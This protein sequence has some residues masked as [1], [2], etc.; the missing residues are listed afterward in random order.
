MKRYLRSLIER[1]L[2]RLPVSRAVYIQRDQLQQDI[3]GLRAS[4]AVRAV[5][6]T[7]F[8][9]LAEELST[10]SQVMPHEPN[11]LEALVPII[12]TLGQRILMATRCRDADVLPKVANAGA[13]IEQPNGTLVQ[14]MHNGIKVIAGGY[15]GEWMQDLIRRCQG[16]HEP[17]EEVLFAEVLKH[18]SG[19]AA[20]FELGGFWSFYSIWFLSQGRSRRSFVVEADPAHI[21]IGRINAQLN[22]C[23]PLFIHAVVAGHAA[24]PAPVETE[25]SGL[26]ELPSVSVASMMATYG[27]D[28]LDLLHCDA[29]GIELTVLESC[30]ELAANGQLAWVIVS[31]HSHH[32]SGDALTHQRCLAVLGQAGAT[33]LAEHDVQESFSGDGLIVAKFGTVPDSWRTPKLSYNRAS[34]SLFRNP[35]YDL[36]SAQAALST[37]PQPV[38]LSGPMQL[39]A[40]SKTFSARGAMLELAADCALGR[41]GD[42]LLVPFDEVMFPWIVAHGSWEADNLEFLARHIDTTRSYCVIDIGANVG[43]FSR[44]AAIRFPNLL[45]F[46]CVEPDAGN[47]RALQ[48]NLSELLG[49][50]AALWNLALSHADG[51]TRFFRDNGNFGNYS[52]NA[53]AMRDR[54]FNTGT[55][56][57]VATGPWMLEHVSLDMDE[58]LVWK[59]D[60]QGHD[61]L[62]ISLTP[63]AVWDHVDIAI[64]ELWRIMKADFDRDTFVSRIDAFPNKSLGPDRPATTREILAYISSDDWHHTDLYLWR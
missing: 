20:M 47:F 61:E 42:T 49:S 24:P 23:D 36:A 63:A 11:R 33:I 46:T 40:P 26:V 3:K 34:E 48:F 16:H 4:M 51:P 35:L 27:I 62:I 53:D 44:Q 10:T 41:Q 5:E 59:S 25:A 29:Q 57:S 38:A 14:I 52:L 17:Q 31:T 28:H 45:R 37:V 22:G 19:D 39:L 64:I 7:S 56:Q 2:R 6:S 43:L 55:V 21:E 13:V 30:R 32:I 50:R 18:I 8:A 1:S 60:T 54:P 15:Y 9:P 12:R 58:R